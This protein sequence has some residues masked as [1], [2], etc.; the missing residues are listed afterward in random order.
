MKRSMCGLIL[1]AAV[2]GL[3]SC[4]GDPTGDE[5]EQGQTIIA[6]PSSVFLSAGGSKF[7]T[8]QVLDEL[9]NQLPVDFQAQNVGPGIT[10][11]LDTTYL[12][13]TI[14]THL[15]T[16]QRFIVTGT[17]PTATQFELASNGLSDTIPVKVTPTSTAATVSNPA[18]AANEGLVVTLPTAG[19]KFGSGA[20]A[21]IAGATGF[22]SA[23]A[24]D[25][26]SIT[27]LLPPG[28]TG[29]LTVD[30]VGVD[31]APGVLF[32]L[33]TDQTVTVGP[34]T[35][36]AGTGSTGSAP[37]LTI[38]PVGATT[39]FYDGGTYDANMP[40]VTTSGTFP[41]PSRVYKITVADTTALTTE[42]NWPGAED[43]GLYFFA[44]NGTTPFGASA[45]AGGAGGH[46]ESADNTFPP[47]TY[48]MAVMNFADTDPAWISLNITNITE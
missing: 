5:I 1:L 12:Q 10:V 30:S 26:S 18:P 8:V 13:T 44:S 21:N 28:A 43:L 3:G 19:Y 22:T 24:P 17:S 41:I 31:Y 14:G 39:F 46:P 6:D 2:A 25:S 47:G 15:E 23:V 20:G 7:V 35:P 16:A 34:V 42:L 36:Q 11:E 29:T 40:L 32:S 45:D 27:V 38:P 48:Y 9:G 33:E 4:G 37:A